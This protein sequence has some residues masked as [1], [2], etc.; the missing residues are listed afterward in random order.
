MKIKT[1]IK[2]I[3]SGKIMTEHF[4]TRTS[5]CITSKTGHTAVEYAQMIVDYFND[6]IVDPNQSRR[7][8]ISAEKITKARKIVNVGTPGHC[9]YGV[10][11]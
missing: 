4:D 10:K 8:L 5:K 7:E 11:S 2:I 6:T 9:N 3:N 1:Q